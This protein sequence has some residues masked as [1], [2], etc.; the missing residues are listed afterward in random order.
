MRG[1]AEA[2]RLLPCQQTDLAGHIPH[3]RRIDKQHKIGSKLAQQP[4]LVFGRGAR[5]NYQQTIIPRKAR[6]QCTRNGNSGGVIA[7]Q[8]VSDANR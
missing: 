4:G 1:R 5:I 3:L 8:F 7:V 6:L 2:G